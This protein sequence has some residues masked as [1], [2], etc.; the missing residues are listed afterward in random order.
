[1]LT[2]GIRAAEIALRNPAAF[3]ALN[4]LR[5]KL[6]QLLI[7]AGTILSLE[8]LK[9]AQNRGA[10]FGVSLGLSAE[11]LA[12]AHARDF[13]FA[14]GISTPSDIHQALE[15][16]CWQLLPNRCDIAQPGGQAWSQF[17]PSFRLP[18]RAAHL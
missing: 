11:V 2:G 7:G 16:D 6:P 5:A 12:A 9:E 15:W 13:P 18:P 14:P 1:L 10:S 3:D 8:Q 4:S 17:R